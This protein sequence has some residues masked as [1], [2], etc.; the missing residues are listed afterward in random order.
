M[1]AALVAGCTTSGG[2]VLPSISPA[3]TTTTTQ[4]TTTAQATTTTP[5]TVTS[6]ADLAGQPCQALS[7]AA[8]EELDVILDPTE[9][10]LNG[11]SCQWFTTEGLISFTPYP[12]VD[13]TTAAEHQHLTPSQ[14]DGHKALTGVATHGRDVGC[15]TYVS[16]DAEQSFRIMVSPDRGATAADVCGLATEFATAVVA[17]LP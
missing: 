1:T 8:S 11:K 2:G 5:A 13:Q 9:A 6:F 10:D 4:S 15:T 17:G 12:S 3:W 7:R 14:I 16:V